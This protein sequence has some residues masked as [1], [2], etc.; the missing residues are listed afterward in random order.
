MTTTPEG[1]ERNLFEVATNGADVKTNNETAAAIFEG[2]RQIGSVA[3]KLAALETEEK[4]Y[5][6]RLVEIQDSKEVLADS[7]H[8]ELLE[9]RETIN[10]AIF[11]GELKDKDAL[12]TTIAFIETWNKLPMGP[13]N[14]PVD[15]ATSFALFETLKPGEFVVLRDNRGKLKAIT[16]D[17]VPQPFVMSGINGR[18]PHI[19][20]LINDNPE[21][22]TEDMVKTTA[23]ESHMHVGAENA[24]A[25]AMEYIENIFDHTRKIREDVLDDLITLGSLAEL[26]NDDELTQS[27]KKR[28]IGSAIHI[29][30]EGLDGD[31]D[32]DELTAAVDVLAEYDPE[33]LRQVEE[34]AAVNI[35][36][37]MV[38]G[39]SQLS[40][41]KID[42]AYSLLA[43]DLGITTEGRKRPTKIQKLICL[44]ELAQRGE[45]FYNNGN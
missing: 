13:G 42:V 36:T 34:L 15:K 26:L 35:Y 4:E 37:T 9:L 32:F 17:S 5:Q 39:Y 3:V 28:L 20:Y 38:R 19:G 11:S 7:T 30:H 45:F 2:L 16:L 44:T 25:Y 31:G 14:I 40:E 1:D 18:S 29:M 27:V 10:S 24:K 6:D 21:N 41:S 33:A 12:S 22:K 8:D 43:S 23:S